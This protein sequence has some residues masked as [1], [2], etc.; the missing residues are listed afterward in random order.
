M[1]IQVTRYFFRLLVGQPRLGVI[2]DLYLDPGAYGLTAAAVRGYIDAD[3]ERCYRLPLGRL[4]NG[5]KLLSDVASGAYASAVAAFPGL[6]AVEVADLTQAGQDLRA[7]F[8]RAYQVPDG[9]DDDAWVPRFLEYQF[10]CET[11]G[12]GSSPT[13]LAADQYADGRLDWFA[14]DVDTSSAPAPPGHDGE[15]EPAE[16]ALSFIPAP[17]TFSGMPNPRYWEIENRRTEFADID[18]NTTDIAKLLMVEFAIVYSNDWCVIPYVVDVGSLNSLPGLLVTDDFGETTLVRAAGHGANDAWQRWAMFTLGNKVRGGPADVRLFVPPPC[19]SQWRA[20]WSNRWYSCATRWRT[21]YGQSRRSSQWPPAG[22]PTATFCVPPRLP[23]R[24]RG[25]PHPRERAMSSG[26]TCRPTGIRSSRS[27]CPATPA[28]SSCSG[29]ACLSRETF[30]VVF[31][32]C[33]PRTT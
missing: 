25:I 2:R 33:P 27:T 3:A 14:F 18:A 31:C 28:V 24:R 29:R 6:S 17:V 8:R 30:L 15:G 20:T 16:H 10:A 12:P 32:K 22:G 13:V 19:P 26:P 11:T 7:W 9:P 1:H 5:A 23:R 21:W 4:L